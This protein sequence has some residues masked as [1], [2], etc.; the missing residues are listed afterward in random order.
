MKI[1]LIKNGRLYNYVLP[2]E[3]KDNF[4]IK[5][6]DNFDNERNLINVVADN[7]KWVLMSNYETKIVDSVNT[8]DQVYLQEYQFY[9]LR[10]DNEKNYY[11]LYAIPDIEKNYVSYNINSTASL[12]I[13]GNPNNSIVYKSVLVSDIHAKLDYNNCLWQITD[14]SS[15]FG[16]YVNDTRINGTKVLNYGDIIFIAGLKIIVMKDFLLINNVNNNV[17]VSTSLLTI[18]EQINYPID[19]TVLKDEELNRNLYAKEEYFYRSPRFI[20]DIYQEEINI[21]NPPAKVKQ[22]ETSLILTIGPMFTMA[23][24]SFTTVFTTIININNGNSTWKQSIPSFVVAGSM[25]MSMLIWPLISRVIDQKKRKRDEQNRI[26]KYTAYLDQKAKEI[27]SIINKQSQTLKDKYI[28][29]EECANIIMR[30]KSNLWERSIDQKDF[31]SLRLG[32][33]NM[34]VCADIKYSKES[35]SMEQDVLKEKIK[36]VVETRKMLI[37]V[38]I[39]ISLTEKNITSII[40]N[41]KILHDFFK[42]LLLQLMTFHSYEFL[43]IIVLTNHEN[44]SQFEYL[45]NIPYLFDNER[46]IRFFGTN[47]DETKE[48]SLYLERIYQDRK[49]DDKRKY[50]DNPPYYLILTDNYHMY[51]DIEII[52]DVLH[53]TENYG[54]SLMIFSERLANLPSECK[55]FINV[56]EERSGIFESE[57]SI[58]NQKEFQTEFC[59]DI[60]IIECIRKISNIPIEFNDD[61][62]SLPTT[63]SFLGMY[64]V[65]RVEQLNVLQRYQKNNSQKS[66]AVPIGIEKSGSLLKLDLHEKY[67]GPH[68][69]IAGMTGSGKSEFIITYILS[70]A[71]NFSPLDVAFILI[72]YKGGGLAGAFENRETGVCLPHLAGTITNLDV[73][74]M[75]RSLSSIQ[76]ELRR[77]QQLFNEARDKLGESTVDIYKYQKF[78]KEGKV[79]QAVPHLFIISDEFAELK[80]SQPEFM[81]QLIQAARIGRS[82][83]IH[84]ILATQ[85]PS[86]V[87]NDQIWSNSRFRVCLKVQEKSDSNEMIKAPDAAFLKQAGRF[88]L[89]VGYNEL[90]ALGQSAWCGAQY[91]PTDKIKKKIDQ[92]V[93]IIDNIGNVVSQFDDMDN[94]KIPSNGDELSNVLAHVIKV[95]QEKNYKSPKL[96]LEKILPNIYVDNLVKKYSYHEEEFVLKP[97]IGE[98]DDPNNQ[99][100]DLLTLDLTGDGNIS[101]YGSSGSGKEMLLSSVIYSLVTNHTPNEVNIYIAEFG[102]GTLGNFRDVPHVGDVILLNEEEKIVNLFKMLEGELEV[103]KKLFVDYNG[104]YQNYIKRSGKT[105]PYVLLIINNYDVFQE[106]FDYEEVMN[107]LSRECAKYGIIILTSINTTSGMRYRL[108][109]NFKSD[110]T[111]QFNDQDDY[112][113][114]IGNIRKLYPSNIYGRGLVKLDNIYEFQTAHIFSDEEYANKL[115]EVIKNL[116]NQYSIKAPKVPVVPEVVY[117]NDLITDIRGLKGVPVGIN[118]DS[119]LPELFNFQDNYATLISAN[120]INNTTK[121]IKGIVEIIHNIH[122]TNIVMIDTE[123]LVT[124]NDTNITYINTNLDEAIKKISDSMDYEYTQYKEANYNLNVLV[125]SKNMFI[126]L[127]NFSKLLMK[128]TDDN[129]KRFLENLEKAKD[130][131]VFTYLI[132][133]EVDSLKKFEYEPWY[134]NAIQNNYGIWIGNGVADQN[135]IKT[136]IGFKK[137]NNE[138]KEG[139]G[140]VIKNSK[141][142]LV[143]LVVED[144]NNNSKEDII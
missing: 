118:K 37:N 98:L 121:F 114:I 43:K 17:K 39:T 36:E 95:C 65:G 28:P 135:L 141:T 127:M 4:W 85:K 133:D 71:V 58:G 117:A 136:N 140:I 3:I 67:H 11:Y 86:G 101:I 81:E 115:Q 82:L 110:I 132:V 55:N 122:N 32:I 103:R 120:D 13:G 7:G 34:P 112:S 54:F 38:P 119:I 105:L 75:N 87:V 64:N 97:I 129:K 96:W 52:K 93:L 78:Y 113:T 131:K 66:L 57:I 51:R 62:K 59:H 49:A 41:N 5:D 83:G 104:D 90:F 144:I 8:H 94:Q 53:D 48:L 68:G 63:L 123:S 22:E 111:L 33:G 124:N 74:E 142:S 70:M 15:P 18:K 24:T 69:L 42:G 40:G 84:L 9:T 106:T 80:T 25:F 21:D 10:N 50:T 61:N 100:Q 88:Y 92:S 35:F 107:R 128:M 138:V 143:N 30:R 91:Y 44:A 12:T 2:K 16:I 20:E 116:K 126:I 1:L 79:T 26:T 31:L 125:N 109:Q 76:S 99:R 72:D 46:T 14:N 27:D 108:R 19:K 60:D 23:L 6:I 130:L 73:S 29:L 89:Q 77:R 102:S 139:Y 134:K 137:D 47:L 45:R 56:N